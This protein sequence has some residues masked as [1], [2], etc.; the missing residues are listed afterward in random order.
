V[1]CGASFQPALVVQ[2]KVA[3]TCRPQAPIGRRRRSHFLAEVWRRIREPN[4]KATK[5]VLFSV[6]GTNHDDPDLRVALSEFEATL[7]RED[8]T[9]ANIDQ[10]QVKVMLTFD[11]SEHAIEAVCLP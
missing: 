10:D 11:R 5:R 2:A 1:N 3:R 8:T 4:T 9:H 7:K 6:R